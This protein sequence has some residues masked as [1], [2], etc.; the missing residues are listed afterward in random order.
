VAAR[1]TT[2]AAKVV[3]AP[4]LS[5]LIA[6][7]LLHGNGSGS[8]YALLFVAVPFAL[9]LATSLT[10]GN[11]AAALPAALLSAAIGLASWLFVASVLAS[12][13]AD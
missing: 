7:A 8:T 13:F 4:C 6:L 2:V 5:W 1:R 11:R 3:A 10:A 9:T 12:K